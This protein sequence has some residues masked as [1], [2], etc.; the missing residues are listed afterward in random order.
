MRIDIIGSILLTLFLML[1]AHLFQF[2]VFGCIIL[3]IVSFGV[4]NY[5]GKIRIFFSNIRFRKTIKR[6]VKS[7][8]EVMDME[9]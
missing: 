7:S 1:I 4:L 6:N 5:W 2:G 9:E 3:M 8:Y